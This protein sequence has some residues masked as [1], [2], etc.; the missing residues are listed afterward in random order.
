MLYSIGRVTRNYGA[1]Q[2]EPVGFC[3]LCMCGLGGFRII[4]V[5]L[6]FLYNL[7]LS[8]SP[9]ANAPTRSGKMC[10]L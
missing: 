2:R 8:D 4:R 10:R 7:I 9:S 3:L 5:L 1:H 6:S